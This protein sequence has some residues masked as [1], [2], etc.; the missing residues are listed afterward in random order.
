MTLTNISVIIV[1]MVHSEYTPKPQLVEAPVTPC[2]ELMALAI[3]R[4]EQYLAPN[5]ELGVDEILFPENGRKKRIQRRALELL[6]LD[7]PLS[8]L[9]KCARQGYE[10]REQYGVWGGFLASDL[11]TMTSEEFEEEL[12]K[13]LHE[14]RA[15]QLHGN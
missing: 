7:C 1:A 3:D 4:H 11:R 10:G 13:R 9:E 14:A 5:E 8:A 6:C 12:H 2:Q 15:R